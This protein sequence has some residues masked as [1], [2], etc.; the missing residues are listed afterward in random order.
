MFYQ[1][2]VSLM[3]SSFSFR[4][5]FEKTGGKRSCHTLC[6]WSEVFLL[7]LVFISLDLFHHMGDGTHVDALWISSANRGDSLD[8][9]IDEENRA[10]KDFL[11]LVSKHNSL[12][13]LPFVA[14]LFKFLL[15]DVV[16]LMLTKYDG[17]LGESRGSP[18]RV[19]KESQILLQC[20][21]SEL[22][23]R[24]LCQSWWQRWPRSW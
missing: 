22:G 6:G 4:W 16:W 3:E 12:S 17:L 15:T 5:C 8:R 24:V 7:T 13:L 11:I 19:T 18:R 10:A 9:K 23:C 21:C 14:C 1:T 20:C 2:S